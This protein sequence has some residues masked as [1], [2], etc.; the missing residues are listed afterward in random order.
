MEITHIPPSDSWL[1]VFEEMHPEVIRWDT[2]YKREVVEEDNLSFWVIDKEN[3]DL[4]LGEF[5]LGKRDWWDNVDLMSISSLKKGVGNYMWQYL[6]RLMRSK[7][8]DR[9]VGEARPGASWYLAQ[10][11]GAIKVGNVPN[12]GGTGETYV[13]FYIDLKK[14]L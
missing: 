5:I 7:G 11:Y 13:E 2:E 10:K 12:H 4:Y 8:I 6:I 1:T 3:P 9:M 14:V